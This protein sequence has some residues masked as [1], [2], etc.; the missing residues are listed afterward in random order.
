MPPRPLTALAI[1][2]LAGSTRADDFD[3][4]EGRVLS[5]VPKSAE[6]TARSQL[7]T[8]DLGNLPNLLVGT[9]SPLVIVK[10]GEAN[11]ARMLV[12]PALRK[13][14][15]ADGEPIPILVVE[16]FDAF[17]GNAATRR[18]AKG[19]E[20]T[21]FDGFRL[22]LDSGQVVPEGQGGDVQFLAGGEGGPRLVALKGSTMFTLTKSPLGQAEAAHR[23]SPGRTVLKGDFAGNF[24]LFANGQTSGPLELKVDEDGAVTGRLRSDQTGGSYKVTGQAGGDP[25]NKIRFAIELPRARQEF[26]GF[27]FVEGKGAIAGSFVLLDR[28]FGFFAVREGGTLAPDGEDVTDK[29]GDEGGR[30]KLIID[31]KAAA[32]SISGKTLDAAGLAIAVEAA[33]AADPAT[34]VL[35]R[36]EPAA[37]A[38]D[39]LKLAEELRKVGV[40]KIKLVPALHD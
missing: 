31:V 12:S 36:V 3:R 29:I 9:R 26:D 14:P 34:W 23:P 7:T 15:V 22:D 39:V 16:K 5:N 24:R 40:T 30:G 25:T 33:L 17:E 11:F 27:L 13:S 28:T 1:L 37:R 4:L 32:L 10:T 21:L 38:G 8:A 6:S 19:G 20:L 35:L 2:L 18:L